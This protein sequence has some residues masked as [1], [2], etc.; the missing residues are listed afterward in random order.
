M[1]L[2]VLASV[3]ALALVVVL[4]A[5]VVHAGLRVI[6]VRRLDG[7]QDL[8]ALL[9]QV[10][11]L[12]DLGGVEQVVQVLHLGLQSGGVRVFQDLLERLW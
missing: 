8:Q 3:A 12:Q 2:G 1:L 9:L 10:L 11:D 4:R 5:A 6:L 7:L